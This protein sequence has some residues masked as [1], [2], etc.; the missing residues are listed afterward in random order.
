MPEE[1]LALRA[2]R[3]QAAVAAYVDAAGARRR[4]PGLQV[5]VRVEG[6]RVVVETGASLD[7][8]LTVPGGQEEPLVAAEAA[9]VITPG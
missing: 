5:E 7:L 3:A 2:D 8:P 4:Y 9:A 1:R 6:D